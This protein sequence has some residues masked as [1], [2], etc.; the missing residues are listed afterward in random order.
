[1]KT[2]LWTIDIIDKIIDHRF[3]KKQI[4]STYDRQ[5]MGFFDSAATLQVNHKNHS[6]MADI[7]S[8]RLNDSLKR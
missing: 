7:L 6:K 3:K 8:L 1:M 4:F 2:P 5:H